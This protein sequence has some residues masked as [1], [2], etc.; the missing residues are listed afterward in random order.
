MKNPRINEPASSDM[1]PGG[2]PGPKRTEYL[3]AYRLMLLAGR[4]R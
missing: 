1:L 2:L 4:R 3:K